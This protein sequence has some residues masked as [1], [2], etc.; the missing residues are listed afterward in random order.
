MSAQPEEQIITARKEHLEE[1]LTMAV[2]LWPDQNYESLKAI[3]LEILSAEKFKILLF[4]ESGEGAGFIYLSIRTDY[5]EGSES[6]P[7]GYIEG[8]YVKPD[9]RRKGISRK[10]LQAGEAWIKSRNCTQIGSDTSLDN[11]VSYDFH[12]SVGFKEAGRII[13][14]IKN[15]E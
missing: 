10:L 8:I 1:L 14:F 13:A 6:S 2:D 12:T 5:V 11:T 3:F 15:L 4:R 7:T 9:F